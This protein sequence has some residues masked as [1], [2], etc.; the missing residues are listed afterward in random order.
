MIL[1]PT[2]IKSPVIRGLASIDLNLETLLLINRV[3]L[4]DQFSPTPS[5]TIAYGSA[6]GYFAP[7][8]PMNIMEGRRLLTSWIVP[9]VVST[10]LIPAKTV[11]SVFSVAVH[12]RSPLATFT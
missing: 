5:A 3:H 10:K 1:F 11:Y 2:P 9:K 12:I 7:T 4:E 6:A 8:A